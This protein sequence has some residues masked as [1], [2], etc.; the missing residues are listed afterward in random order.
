M[1]LRLLQ[2]CPASKPA[3]RKD[4]YPKTPRN[5][6][7]RTKVSFSLSF[8]NPDNTAPYSPTLISNPNLHSQLL[9]ANFPILPSKMALGFAL[10]RNGTCLL[11]SETDCGATVSPYHA[12]CPSGSFCSPGQF[13]VACC[14]SMANCTET[15]VQ[16]PLCANES[17]DMYNNDGP[18]CCEKGGVGYNL[19]GSDGCT[20]PGAALPQGAILLVVVSEGGSGK[21]DVASL[22]GGL[23]EGML[24]WGGERMCER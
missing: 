12:C 21:R 4:K 17:W 24:L 15:L 7:L 3:K 18:F 10:R 5:N 1:T 16:T 19:Q 20:S 14:P 23:W 6:G 11:P 13:N 8:Q 9:T 2:P 22:F